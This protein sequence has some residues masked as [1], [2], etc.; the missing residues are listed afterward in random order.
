MQGTWSPYKAGGVGIWTI[1]IVLEV[2]YFGFVGVA[3]ALVVSFTINIQENITRTFGDNI[4]EIKLQSYTTMIA[5]FISLFLAILTLKFELFYV[6]E[7]TPRSILELIAL[8]AIFAVVLIVV[9]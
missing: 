7:G 4:D 5:A 3:L 6:T 8:Y 1:L 9:R 2:F